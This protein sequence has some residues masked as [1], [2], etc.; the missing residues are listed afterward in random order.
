MSVLN[1]AV[2][3]FAVRNKNCLRSLVNLYM[4]V[5]RSYWVTSVADPGG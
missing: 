2:Q 1:A 5:T 3:Q 4:S